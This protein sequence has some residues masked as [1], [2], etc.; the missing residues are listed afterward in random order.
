MS[1]PTPQ[2]HPLLAPGL[3]VLGSLAL[4]A[5]LLLLGALF[6]AG[7]GAIAVALVVD[8]GARPALAGAGAFA[9]AAWAYLALAFCVGFI[10]G[11]RRLV[12]QLERIERGQLDPLPPAPGRDEIAQ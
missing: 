4:P 8:G 6:A 7:V 12:A 3:R 11:L 2:T 5:K 10:G 1:A 9:L